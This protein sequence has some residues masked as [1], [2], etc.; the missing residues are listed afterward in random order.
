ML[1]LACATGEVT[2]V[3]I[4]SVLS[5]ASLSLSPLCVVTVL[6]STVAFATVDGTRATTVKLAVAAL[7]S[8]AAEQ[9]TV[10]PVPAGV[11][12]Q[13]QPA[14]GVTDENVAA[15]G[16]TSVIEGLVAA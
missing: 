15:A 2:V 7:A 1:R 3:V 5:V 4:V 6:V 16:S 13:V 8:V 14:G 12:T 10:P 11:V 9:R